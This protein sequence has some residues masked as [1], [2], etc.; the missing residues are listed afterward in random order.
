MQS[1][2]VTCS[3]KQH[4]AIYFHINVELHKFIAIG[5]GIL[6]YSSSEEK[7]EVQI[8]NNVQSCAASTPHIC[9]ELTTV[10]Y[11][12]TIVIKITTQTI[13]L[14]SVIM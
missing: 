3:Y 4:N 6:S 11:V 9:I 5:Q 10:M 12:D 8:Q 13:T 7:K 1:L 2:F 14:T